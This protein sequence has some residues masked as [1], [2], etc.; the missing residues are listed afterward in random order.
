MLHIRRH[1]A[2]LGAAALIAACGKSASPGGSDA[3]L[4][5][6]PADTPYAYANLEPMPADVLAAQSKHMHAFWPL[7][8]EQYDAMLS[9][10]A[11]G[12][13]P[14]KVISA[15]LDELRTRDSFDKLRELGFKPDGRLA[16]YGVGLIPVLR[17]ELSDP[18]AFKAMLARIEAKIGEKI[19]TGKTGAQEYWQFGD[20]HMSF[21]VAV[22]NSHLVLTLWA[23]DASDAVKQTLLGLTRPAKTLADAGTLQGIAKQYGYTPYGEGYFD[24]IALVQRLSSA[25]TGNDL[26]IAKAMKLPADGAITDPVCKSEFLAIAQTFPRVLIGAETVAPNHM[27]IGVQFEIATTLAQQLAATLTPA[28]GTGTAAQGLMD[29]SLSLP[30]LKLKDFWLKQAD[31]VVAKP[32]ACAALAGL[33]E[34]FRSSKAKID[35]T[36]PPPLSDLTGVRVTLSRINPGATPS[37][38]PDVAGK[39]LFGTSNPL[40]AIGMAQIAVPQLKDL[41]ITTDGKAVALPAGLAPGVPVPPMTLAVSDKAIALATGKGEEANLGEFLAAAPAASP[42]FMRMQFS[43]AIYG[44]MARYSD[45]FNRTLRSGKHSAVDQTKLFAL[46]EKMLRT[47][48]FSF[49][50]N[51]H[52]IAMHETVDTQPVD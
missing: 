17:L 13:K 49:E 44:L 8:L 51:A 5:F 28:P 18:A 52:G 20:A 12:E 46:Y 23:P 24:A 21:V 41:K 40:A 47:I 48:E 27:K 19:P 42:V 16:V 26:E 36:I 35:T 7:L 10:A 9:D 38:T 33:N 43:G 14:R 4:A 11:L 1:A 29:F 39:F 15:V 30:I 3:P 25:P 31:A 34:S 6:A 2:L 45:M 37:A 22:Q 32:Y 50:A